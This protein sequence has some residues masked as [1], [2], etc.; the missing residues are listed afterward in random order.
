M[1][2]K[3]WN[4]IRNLSRANPLVFV[5]VIAFVGLYLFIRDLVKW[6]AIYYS[7]SRIRQRVAVACV[8]CLS[9]A[10]ISPGIALISWAEEQ[11]LT[12]DT[13]QGDTD[14]PGAYGTDGELGDDTPDTENP[15]VNTS[16]AAIQDAVPQDSGGI[17]GTD[18]D[19]GTENNNATVPDDGLEGSNTTVSDDG[20]GGSNAVAADDGNGMEDSDGTADTVPSGETDTADE[21]AA[22][23]DTVLGYRSGIE[24]KIVEYK[25]TPEYKEKIEEQSIEPTIDKLPEYKY[26]LYIK[27]IRNNDIIGINICSESVRF[28][29]E[30]EKVETVVIDEKVEKDAE[31]YIPIVPIEDTS[32]LFEDSEGNPVEAFPIEVYVEDETEPEKLELTHEELLAVIDYGS[33]KPA[34]DIP[35][36]EDVTGSDT[37]TKKADES[38]ETKEENEVHTHGS[39]GVK[40]ATVESKLST[41]PSSSMIEDTEEADPKDKS[42]EVVADPKDES[43]EV[44]ADTAS[45]RPVSLEQEASD[46][47][48]VKSA[49]S[50]EALDTEDILDDPDDTDAVESTVLR[51]KNA[52]DTSDKP[53]DDNSDEAVEEE[54]DIIR[55]TLPT[56]FDIPMLRNGNGLDVYSEPITIS[57]K[58]G[59]P[60]DMT[61]RSVDVDI[62]QGFASDGLYKATV[63]TENDKP[64][65]LEKISRYSSFQMHLETTDAEDEV[66]WLEN[67]YNENVFSTMLDGG[68]SGSGTDASLYLRGRLMDG[69]YYDGM[70]CN[71]RVRVIFSFK[72]H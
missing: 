23:D 40:N 28:V 49:V 44:A 54:N 1:K 5:V 57:N 6:E 27:N 72:K 63:K 52:E 46:S 50:D 4:K 70:T 59:F 45:S 29:Y 42:T 38:T 7:R 31:L 14:T 55:V 19:N 13:V 35:Q 66:V 67:G 10:A 20:L 33:E 65:D 37:E 3:L 51:E 8:A 34:A 2:K 39:S 71:L 9:I 36:A 21:E 17:D 15:I 22:Y 41:V 32:H 26:L 11:V 68:A 25:D 47:G 18:A 12:T 16:D 61:V 30:D 48:A 60:V 43:T 58:S 24:L 64:Y 62:R 56:S 53:S 69:I